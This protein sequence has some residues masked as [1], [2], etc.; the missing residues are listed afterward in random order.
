MINNICIFHK[1]MAKLFI[2]IVK[3]KTK[4]KQPMHC[5][6]FFLYFFYITLQIIEQYL[7]RWDIDAS[8]WVQNSFETCVN[9]I[10]FLL[11]L[12]SRNYFYLCSWFST[13]YR[14]EISHLKILL[15]LLSTILSKILPM[16][17]LLLPQ[18]SV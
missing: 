13:I 16:R 1:K 10:L 4:K 3:K 15:K 11:A 7:F 2:L 12:S 9:T 18:K 17:S 8:V 14:S 6:D 5:N